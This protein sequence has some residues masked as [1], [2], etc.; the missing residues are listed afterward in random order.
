MIHQIKT[1]RPPNVVS[2]VSSFGRLSVRSFLRSFV[3]L[4]AQVRLYVKLLTHKLPRPHLH[5]FG[6]IHIVCKYVLLAGLSLPHET[7]HNSTC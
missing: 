4:S 2:F 7:F 6:S 5:M 1:P 3:N